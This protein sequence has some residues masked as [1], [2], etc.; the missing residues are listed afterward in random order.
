MR[1]SADH[2]AETLLS[3]L[4]LQVVVSKRGHE[5]LRN[6]CLATSKQIVAASERCEL[7]SQAASTTCRESQTF[8]AFRAISSTLIIRGKHQLSM[9]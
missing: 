9:L 3:V 4:D 1:N 8:Q 7:G 6:I 2:L 5:N